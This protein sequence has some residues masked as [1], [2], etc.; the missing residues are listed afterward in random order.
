MQRTS[1]ENEIFGA[2]AYVLCSMCFLLYFVTWNGR[3]KRQKNVSSHFHREE[4]THD[5]L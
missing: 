4:N 3:R 5:K 2:V 1:F